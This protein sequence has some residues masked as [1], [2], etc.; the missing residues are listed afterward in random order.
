MN[1]AE[2]KSKSTTEVVQA[3]IDA[4]NRGDAAAF[5]GAFS[6]DLHFKMPGTT[7]VSG[8]TH[9]IEAFT[10]IVTNVA[11]HLSVLITIKVTNFISCSEWV[12]TEAECRREK[13]FTPPMR[14]STPKR[15]PRRTPRRRTTPGPVR[16]ALTTT[17]AAR[18]PTAAATR[19]C[20]NCSAGSRWLMFDG[21]AVPFIKDKSIR[22]IAMT[23]IRRSR[24][25]P[26]V[27]TFNETVSKGFDAV[28]WSALLAPPR[29]PA[30]I[31]DKLNAAMRQIAEVPAIKKWFEE[32]GLEVP[33][34]SPAELTDFMKA[35]I[36][37]WVQVAKDN[38]LKI[39]MQ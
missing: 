26:D 32:S 14:I 15:V 13:T 25:L 19:R 16:Q 22:A 28:A 4:L 35:D 7:P 11:N 23:S 31:V 2:T 17:T 18:M 36:E 8:E 38:N 6:D 20:E 30:P 5:I 29:T 9:G 24:V 27:P 3:A 37:K 33:M 34:S 1:T 39:E 10:Q 12:V 21:T